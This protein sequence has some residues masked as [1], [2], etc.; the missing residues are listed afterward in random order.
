VGSN[1]P[2]WSSD[3]HQA[4]WIAPRLSPWEDEYTITIVVPA[5]FE[6]YVRVLHPAETP[7]DRDHLVRWADVAA[8]SGM[9]LRKDA[10][11]HSIALPPTGPQRAAPAQQPGLAGG[12]PLRA[13]RRSPRRDPVG[14]H[15][16]AVVADLRCRGWTG[17]GH[18]GAVV[19]S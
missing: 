18:A 19:T 13:G 1:P 10:Q 12:Q 4:D 16:V 5:G 17:G 3:V 15:Y 6:A 2:L 8:W 9:L 11:F 7:D 14:F